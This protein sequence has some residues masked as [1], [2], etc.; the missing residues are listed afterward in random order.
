MVGQQ[1][2]MFGSALTYRVQV[3]QP[4]NVYKDV[5]ERPKSPVKY[6]LDQQ[7]FR[8]R[9]DL[10]KL[11]LAIDAADNPS[12]YNREDLHRIYRECLRDP[13]L[14]GQW[15]SRKMKTKEKKFKICATNGKEDMEMTKILEKSWFI[16]WVDA[17]LDSKMWGF[18]MMEMGPLVEGQFL[19]Y[20]VGNRFYDPVN[21]LDR[22]NIKPEWG[23]ITQMPG[24]TTGIAFDD[25][26]YTQ[27]LM[28]VGKVRDYGIM[29]SL[30]KYILFKD[31]CLGNWSEWAEV[32]GMDK[33]VGYTD[34]DGEDRN[35]FITAIKNLGSN[36]YG[37]FTKNDKVEFLGTN[38]TDAYKVYDEFV[39]YVDEQVSKKVFGQ[40]VVSNNTGRVVGTV[41]ENM[42][43]MYGDNDARF[44]RN[45]VNDR[46]FPF[47][48]N[49]GFS[50]SGYTFEWDTSEKLSLIDRSEVDKRIAEMGFDIDEKYIT[51]TYGTPVK[52]KELPEMGADPLKTA[53]E[54]KALYAGTD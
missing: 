4:V 8:T 35:R 49:L 27:N 17:C 50:W 22:D 13:N 37:V 21:V 14:S 16:D 47:M 28:F 3:E 48:E 20:K 2:N 15:E 43:N 41:G 11:R 25:P 26:A 9:E 53:K 30:V 42:A 44:I 19:N 34:T 52:K 54:I 51:D 18:T 1:L 5:K 38:R 24:H 10:R 33:R 40:D 29:Y 32:F 36:A 6:I 31:N 46:L 23:I 7:K 45:L 12:S 39:N